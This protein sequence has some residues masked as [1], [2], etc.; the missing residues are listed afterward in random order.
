M[1]NPVFLVLLCT[2]LIVA[3]QI[4]C[5]WWLT[6]S[7]KE[8]VCNMKEVKYVLLAQTYGQP[9]QSWVTFKGPCLERTR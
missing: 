5:T 6:E 3:A 8:T 2:A 4:G 7:N 9:V 1:K